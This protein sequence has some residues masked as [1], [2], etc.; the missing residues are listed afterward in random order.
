MSHVGRLTKKLWTGSQVDLENARK[1]S[2]LLHCDK[3]S[4]RGL[5]S[6]LS[7]YTTD[8]CKVKLRRLMYHFLHR[9]YCLMLG[10]H[11]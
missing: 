3:D 11:L 4:R 2:V 1:T 9:G 8:G 7:P 6:V 5:R 10:A